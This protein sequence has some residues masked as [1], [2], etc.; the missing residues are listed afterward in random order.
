MSDRT[1]T[2]GQAAPAAARPRPPMRAGGFGPFGGG[3]MPAEKPMRFG[4]SVR[5]LL[6]RLRPER[7][8]LAGVIGLGVTSVAFMVIGPKILGRATD[9]IFAGA[10]GRRLPSG[11][12][13]AQV[14]AMARA[15]GNSN[16]A[17]LLARMHIVP[18]QGIDF[19]ALGG[20]L[21]LALGLY[22]ASAFFGWVQ[23]YLLNDVVQRTVF[24]LRSDVEDKLS[25]LPLQF[26][27]R[28][29]RGELLSRVTNDIDNVSLSLQQTISQ[30][31]SSLL[32]VVGVI[33]MMFVVSP[34]LAVVMLLTVPHRLQSDPKKCSWRSGQTPES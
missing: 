3:G 1:A 33:V 19:N 24:G 29:P 10:I 8:K 17:D 12:T 25:R 18:G 16:L 2:N 5:R 32:T 26:F 34:L 20:V 11:L 14:I 22:V 21:M 28:Q 9:L 6:N 27:D 4:P 23:G 30:L 7:V 31:L 13:E 15:A